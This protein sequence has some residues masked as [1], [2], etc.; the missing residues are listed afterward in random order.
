MRTL[1]I[2][3]LLALSP[4]S[5]SQS[6]PPRFTME[7]EAL[8]AHLVERLELQPGERFVAVAHPGLFDELIPHLRYA[9]MQAG[10][11]DLGVIDVLAEP[12]PVAWNENV[13]REGGQAAQDAL[14]KM[15]EGVDASI[16]LPGANPAHPVYAAIQ[17]NLRAQR[18]RTIHFHW[19][20]NGSAFP[21]PGQPL[22][23]VH[24]MESVY[25]RAML[26][27]D[28][29]QLSAH[30]RRFEEAMRGGEVRIT[31]TA[32]TDIRFRIGDRPVNFQDGDASG[33]RAERGVVL[34]DREI[35]IPA[36]ALRVAPLEQSV[37]GTIA[38]PP[39][40]W[41]G[42]AVTGLILTFEAGTVVE[43]SAES[44]Q[45]AVEAEMAGAGPAGRAFREFAL[46]FH[47]LLAV[48]EE[49]QWVPYYGYG[50]GVVRLSLGDN[51]ELG[52]SVRGGYV[53]WNFFTDTTVTIDGDLWVSDGKIVK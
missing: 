51:S 52:G 15:L 4:A 12:V 43:I 6:V 18:G 35:E 11:V 14:A 40:Q 3:M 8:A 47:P 42:K 26:Q 46:G 33:P 39:S 10:A 20:Q 25:Q 13:L 50:A 44:G 21:L 34:I 17:D 32:G 49:N 48:P 1:I 7:W 28:Y 9:V 23:P 37:N 53:R 41:S 31:S 2:A 30:Q 38:F 27:A 16:M 29:E 19:L 45:E 36:G 24:V 22:P 5:F